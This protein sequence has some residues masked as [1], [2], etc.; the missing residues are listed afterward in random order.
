MMQVKLMPTTMTTQKAMRQK[1]DPEPEP[2]A[3]AVRSWLSVVQAYNLCDALLARELSTIGLRNAEYEILANL[4]REPGISQQVLAERCFTAKSH[5]SALL[6]GMQERGWLRRENHPTDARAKS[7]YL[8]PE[9]QAMAER[10]KLLQSK[11]V[12]VMVKAISAKQMQQVHEAMLSVNA[13]LEAQL[14]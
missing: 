1:N 10:G 11:V 14:R 6:S 5:I 9:G 12:K 2:S 7:L 3:E 13:A 4:L 8:E